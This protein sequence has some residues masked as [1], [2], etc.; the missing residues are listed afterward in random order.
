MRKFAENTTSEIMAFCR[1]VVV[2]DV[3]SSV[4]WPR[5]LTVFSWGLSYRYSSARKKY[6]PLPVALI[7]KD[8]VTSD[9]IEQLIL[10]MW[11]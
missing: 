2:Q 1:V 6:V 10:S 9:F 8:S 5:L 3:A 11:Y 7:I 4:M